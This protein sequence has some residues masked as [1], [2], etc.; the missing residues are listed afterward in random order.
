MNPSSAKSRPANIFLRGL[1][2]WLALAQALLPI[3]SQSLAAAAPIGPATGSAAILFDKAQRPVVHPSEGSP[4]S[5]PLFSADPA[6][7]EFF[8]APILWRAL[9]PLQKP[10]RVREDQ[11]FAQALLAFYDQGDSQDASH[12]ENFLRGNPDSRWRPSLLLNLGHLYYQSARFS[13]ALQTWKEAWDLSKAATERR[14]RMMANEAGVCLAR[15]YVFLGR[16]GELERLMDDLEARQISGAVAEYLDYCRMSLFQM[17]SRPA[18][19]FRCGPGALSNL[20]AVELADPHPP[21][22]TLEEATENGTSL[23]QMWRLSERM[24]MGYQM[25]KRQRGAPVVYPAMVHW[26]LGHYS[27]LTREERGRF[28]VHDPNF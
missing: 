7:S 10:K 4:V 21:A 14:A 6:D 20:R 11:A 16:R 2:L 1:S 24:G 17:N 12:L 3:S 25:A 27:A 22:I 5:R 15:M 23:D 19:T 28:R 8:R 9:V 13:K 26:K 18:K